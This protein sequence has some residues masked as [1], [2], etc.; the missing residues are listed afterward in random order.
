VGGLCVPF[1]CRGGIDCA[2]GQSCEAGACVVPPEVDVASVVIMSRP[3]PLSPG[4]R[5]TVSALALDE[6]GRPI[7]GVAL[8]FTSTESDVARFDGTVLVAGSEAGVTEVSAYDAGAGAPVSEPITVRNLGAGDERQVFVVDMTTGDPIAGASVW[9]GDYQ[10]ET[11]DAGAVR[12]PDSPEAIHVFADGFTH[13]TVV[14]AD[15]VEAVMVPMRRAAEYATGAVEGTVRFDEVSSSGDGALALGGAALSAGLADVS[16]E[17]ILGA[18]VRLEYGIPGLTTE[19]LA[20]PSGVVLALDLLGIGT[21]KADFWSGA[22]PGRTFAWSLAG[23]VDARA[24]LDLLT[25]DG[26]T[27]DLVTRLLPTVT[28]FDH[29]VALLDVSAAAPAPD[30]DDRDGDGDVTEL[31]PD[32][33]AAAEV[34]L[35]PSVSP[36]YRVAV[37]AGSAP[38]IGTA[39]ASSLVLIAGVDVDGV[40]FVPLGMTGARYPEGGRLGELELRLAPPHGGLS[41]GRFAVVALAFAPESVRYSSEAILL[42]DRYVGQV[43]VSGRLPEAIALDA[44]PDGGDEGEADWD[45]ATRRMSF[46]GWDGGLTRVR[47]ESAAG[48]WDVLSA[49]GVDGFLLPEL[50]EEA[51]DVTRDATV[52][53]VRI[54][55]SVPVPDLFAPGSPT[56]RELDGVTSGFRHAPVE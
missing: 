14:G 19:A 25:V 8:A 45:A 47:F 3:G 10:S 44:W 20:L 52:S 13:T 30:T 38:R 23:R 40:G 35:T 46:R 37:D 51:P 26:G 39:E 54:A 15:A 34:V 27:D 28:M 17:G 11:N 21:V 6:R 55:V 43:H 5:V 53:I 33:D 12:R 4:D 16:L 22:R 50:P 2:T 7:P 31:L 36:V 32:Y 48:S 24:L 42:P 9:I 18:S 29:G 41:G 49:P 56:L 1:S